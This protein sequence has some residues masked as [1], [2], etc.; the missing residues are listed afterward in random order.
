MSGKLNNRLHV[1]QFSWLRQ[2]GSFMCEWAYWVQSMEDKEIKRKESFV[3]IFGWSFTICSCFVLSRTFSLYSLA[4]TLAAFLLIFSYFIA[5]NHSNTITVYSLLIHNSFCFCPN[6]CSHWIFMNVWHV[7][8]S[9]KAV[10]VELRSITI[11]N[12]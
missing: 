6:V 10:I 1:V 12:N 4:L 8:I 7:T 5:L 11:W 2:N 3:D 9:T